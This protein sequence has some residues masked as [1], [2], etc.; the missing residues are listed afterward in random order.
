MTVN[1]LKAD[2]KGN[3]IGQGD[4][5]VLLQ[6]IVDTLNEIVDDHATTRSNNVALTTAVNAIIA[7][8]ATSLDNLTNV[9][10]VTVV[11]AAAPATLSDTTDLTLLAP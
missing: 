1:T 5:V 2:I 6:N 9:A 3:G 8:A 10:A 4:L 7:A 11:S